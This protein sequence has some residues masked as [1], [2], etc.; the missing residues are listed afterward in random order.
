MKKEVVIPADV[1]PA[2]RALFKKN[3][4]TLT[5]NTNHIALFAADQKI[6]HLHD[7][8]SGKGKPAEC[9]DPEHIFKIMSHQHMGALATQYGL[10]SRYGLQYNKI[11][12][13]VKI[14]SKTHLVKQQDPLSKQL[15]SF[16]DVFAL[17]KHVPILGVGYTIY[18]G[19]SYEAEMISEAGQLMADC[20]AH[21]LLGLLWIYPR[22]KAVKNPDAIH[23]IAG[24]AGVAACLGADIVK[25]RYPGQ[26]RK[27]KDVAAAAG[28]TKVICAGGKARNPKQFLKDIH[29]Q[30]HVAGCSGNATGRNIFTKPLYKAVKMTK[31]IAAI[32]YKNASLKEAQKLL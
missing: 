10:I 13:I 19:S 12:Y 27:F 29:D 20:H 32:T 9:A 28:N 8:F 30:I 2:K 31:A 4:L 21:G 16:Q 14:N 18:L 15:V 11:P 6:E 26:A 1:P 7:D 25:V 22:G 5:K 3:L 24:S 17:S 23:L